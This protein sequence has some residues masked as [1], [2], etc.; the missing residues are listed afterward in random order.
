MNQQGITI[1]TL[2]IL[3]LVVILFQARRYLR[4]VNSTI[5]LPRFI[6]DHLILEPVIFLFRWFPGGWGVIARTLLYKILLK[7]MGKSVTI[8]DGVKIMFPDQVSIGNYSGINDSCFLDGTGGITL[9]EY[10][11]LAPRVEIMTSNHR[12]D[13]P[14]T[15]I[16]LQGLDL[17]PVV[18]EDDVWIG[19]GALIVPG[20]RIGKGSVIGGHA[21]VTKD[22]PPYSIA[23]GVPAT[24]IGSRKAST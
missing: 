17:K 3:V 1:L 10:V 20:V 11:R 12:Y 14:N 2:L 4:A 18:I 15:P 9:G 7:K 19:I 16:K 22:V 13:D 23:A 8:R 21:V 6:M 24:I 5:T